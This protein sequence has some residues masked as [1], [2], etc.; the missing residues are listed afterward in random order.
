MRVSNPISFKEATRLIESKGLMPTT[1]SSR[2]LEQL[3]ADITERAF[4]SAKVSD[5]D[6]L[7][8]AKKRITKIVDPVNRKPGEYMDKGRFE[9]EMREYLKSIGYTPE[10]GKEGSLQDLSSTRR[11]ELIAEMNTAE[12]RGYGQF[13]QANDPAVLSAF[14]AQ[15]LYRLKYRKEPRDWIQRWLDKGGTLYN[16]RMIALKTSPIWTTLSRFGRPYPPFDFQSGMW[17]KPVNRTTA[18]K[19]GLI[20][21]KTELKPQ[22]RTLNQDLQASTK[23]M[24][25]ELVQRLSNSLEGRLQIIDNAL[26]IIPAKKALGDMYDAVINK[27]TGTPTKANF[28]PVSDHN[29]QLAEDTLSIDIA[30]KA[31]RLDKSYMEHIL[32]RHGELSNDRNQITRE[33]I[34]SLPETQLEWDVV[35]RG[36]QDKQ[37]GSPTIH[38]WVHNM[39]A[40]YIVKTKRLFMVSLFKRNEN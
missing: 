7:A 37:S 4:F 13:I 2:E 19:A 6:I 16:G 15:E 24:P 36:E 5:A 18:I 23:T 39:R 31:L 21:E 27:T 22:K 40:T 25:P 38:A 1:A 9:E 30:D 11:L 29:R 26:H 10:K 14:P 12:A 8:E 34:T 33:D 3:N 17:I 28:L 20:D 32:Q 35:K